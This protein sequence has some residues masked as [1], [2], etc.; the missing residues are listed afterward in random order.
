MPLGKFFKK[1]MGQKCYKESAARKA[2]PAKAAPAQPKEKEIGAITHYFGKI[3]VG[4]IKLK[5]ELKVG[6]TIH[7]KGMHDDFTQ[8]IDS[9]QYEHQSIPTAKK[10]LEVGVKVIRPVHENDKVY[11]Q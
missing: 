7:I 3:Q 11:K 5:A 8:T 10:G 4:I 2:K 6:D 1:L 9:L